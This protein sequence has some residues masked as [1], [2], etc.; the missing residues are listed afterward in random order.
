MLVGFPAINFSTATS[1][2]Q[3]LAHYSDDPRE[4][5]LSRK[6]NRKLQKFIPLKMA[7]EHTGALI[8]LL[9]QYNSKCRGNSAHPGRSDQGQHCLQ[10]ALL[11]SEWPKLYGVLAFLSAT[12][13][14][15]FIQYFL[16]ELVYFS[17]FS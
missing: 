1:L 14:N 7:K 15:S 5:T 9:S 17:K 16:I 11:H 10:L 3:P 6:A 13:L 12:G 8:Y 2:T 4:A